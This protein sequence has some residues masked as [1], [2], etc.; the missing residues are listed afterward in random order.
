VNVTIE[1]QAFG[2]QSSRG[3]SAV[4][5]IRGSES[6][7]DGQRPEPL[8]SVSAVS[9]PVA[10][11]SATVTVFSRGLLG[12][13]ATTMMTVRATL[14]GSTVGTIGFP[15]ESACPGDLRGPPC[16][17]RGASF[18][19]RP[20]N[21]S[22]CSRPEG[23]RLL[24]RTFTTH[25]LTHPVGCLC[26]TE[27]TPPAPRQ[28][29]LAGARERA[30]NENQRPGAFLGG[31]VRKSNG[32]QTWSP[33]ALVALCGLLALGVLGFSSVSAARALA[34]GRAE[35]IAENGGI[36]GSTITGTG[37]AGTLE[38]TAGSTVSCKGNTSSM[39]L[40]SFTK[41]DAVLVKFTGCSTVIGPFKAPC[42]SATGASGEII[43]SH[44]S[45]ELVYL[46]KASGRGGFVLEPET[47]GPIATFG[48]TFLGQ[49]ATLT[50]RGSV[51]GEV[52][53][54]SH[55]VPLV[56]GTAFTLTFGQTK[57]HQELESYL[58]PAT[59]A[60]IPS[61]LET[62]SSGAQSFP[63]TQSG[64]RG[65]E[66]MTTSKKIAIFTSPFDCS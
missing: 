26:S 52:T 49:T 51:V 13:T 27:I 28:L 12:Q 47:A 15:A 8:E 35:I 3:W 25:Q 32:Q 63:S 10:L 4:G 54:V 43:T 38:T 56:Y 60:P 41:L 59:C 62:E 42:K 16:R 9:G 34:A 65:T 2:R 5:S 29:A 46:T 57:G 1:H 58:S 14:V 23:D 64:I 18:G 31:G 55:G 19:R 11:D 24:R 44:L 30:L 48:C 17:W 66:K 53:P 22:S 21:S 7:R 39:T 20:A 50:V 37:E 6:S 33:G 36:A 40:N 45:A 61:V